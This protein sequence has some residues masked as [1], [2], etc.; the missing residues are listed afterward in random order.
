VPGTQAVE[1]RYDG[2]VPAPLE[3]R[4]NLTAEFVEA[5]VRNGLNSM[6][7]FRPTEV[8]DEDLEALVAYLT[9]SR[10]PDGD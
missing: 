8:S 6:P 1:A 10:D 9:R 2:A 7:F 5:I 4:T 3:Q